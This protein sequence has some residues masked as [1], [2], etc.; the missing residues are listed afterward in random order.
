MTDTPTI[1]IAEDDDAEVL[2][3]QAAAKRAG[4]RSDLVFVRDGNALMDYLTGEGSFA[5]PAKPVRPY[6]ILLDLN[7][8][9]MDGRTALDEMRVTAESRTIPVV[10]YSTSTLEEDIE[11]VL[12]HGANSYVTKPASLD[13]IARLLA[14]LESYWLD[15]VARF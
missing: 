13:G 9:G 1:L 3:L 11:G 2:M 6:L 15:T 4:I 10:A 8:P 12:T 14:A 7:M 5:P